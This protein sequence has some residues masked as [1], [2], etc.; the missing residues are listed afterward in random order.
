MS[1]SLEVL[2]T[3]LLALFSHFCLVYGTE[4]AV[5]YDHARMERSAKVE[6]LRGGEPPNAEPDGEI[7]KISESD[8]QTQ[9]A[10]NRFIYFLENFPCRRNDGEYQ[11]LCA[12][13]GR[14]PQL[15]GA[16]DGRGRS[17][18]VYAIKYRRASVI[19]LFLYKG[20]ALE[21]RDGNGDTPLLLAIRENSMEAVVLLLAYGADPAACDAE[22][23]NAHVL[24]CTGRNPDIAAIILKRAPYISRPLNPKSLDRKKGVNIVGKK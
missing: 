20:C 22:G 7:L 16:V 23:F 10:W 4:V 2:G 9:R 15:L 5:R 1:H 24:A 17:L 19:A 18:L 13:L 6:R 8:P 14:H 12:M 21:V 3:F 11:L